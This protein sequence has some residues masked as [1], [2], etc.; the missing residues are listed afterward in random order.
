[1]E[2]AARHRNG[3]ELELEIDALAQG[4]RGVGRANGY[5]VFVA[6]GLPGDRVR[7]RLVRAKRAFAEAKATEILRP[8]SERIVEACVHEGEPCPGAAWQALPYERQ[9]EHKHEQVAEA[10]SR[11][12]G[13]GGLEI[14]PIE[15]AV[16]QWRYRNKLEYS[17]GPRENAVALGFHRR[18]S[19][20]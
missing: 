10:L 3:D 5:V 7:A 8:S 4:G 18:G 16:D 19:W 12:G 6:G 1:M 9:L 15:P 13:F 2:A 11:L 20:S 14:D 17:F